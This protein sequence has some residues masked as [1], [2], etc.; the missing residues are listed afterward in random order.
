M[1]SNKLILK[2]K[3]VRN[4][5]AVQWSGL[6]A[7]LPR[8]WIPS[9]VEELRCL[10]LHGVVKKKNSFLHEYLLTSYYVPGSVAGAGDTAVNN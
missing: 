7:S 4:S 1:Q 9:L 8:I 3:K 6:C 2:N 10:K 5:L